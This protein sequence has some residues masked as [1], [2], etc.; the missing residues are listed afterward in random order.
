MHNGM[1]RSDIRYL[2]R[3]LSLSH[4]HCEKEQLGCAVNHYMHGCTISHFTLTFGTPLP[5]SVCVCAVPHLWYAKRY[6][7]QRGTIQRG[8]DHQ[9]EPESLCPIST[10]LKHT[11]K[12]LHIGSARALRDA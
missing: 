7:E 11:H 3:L 4:Q 9:R 2:H 1:M 5:V 6:A 10:F 8:C 12:H